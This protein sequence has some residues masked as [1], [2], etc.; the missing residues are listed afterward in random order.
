MN[1]KEKL[2]SEAEQADWDALKPHHDRGALFVVS[3]KLDLFVVGEAIA[4]DDVTQVKIWLDNKDLFRL[5]N[6]DKFDKEKFNKIGTFVIV[7][8]Y[9]LLKLDDPLY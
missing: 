2:K 9:V 7:Q 3:D 8:P 5:D 1:L 6:T 4:N